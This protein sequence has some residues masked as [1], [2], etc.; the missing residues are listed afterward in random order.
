MPSSRITSL[1]EGFQFTPPSSART[2]VDDARYYVRAYL[3]RTPTFSFW[4]SVSWDIPTSVCFHSRAYVQH[5]MIPGT[6]YVPDA[7]D[8]RYAQYRYLF[9]RAWVVVRMRAW[10]VVCM[11]PTFRPT[12]RCIA[13]GWW[14]A[15]SLRSAQGTAVS[16]RVPYEVPSSSRRTTKYSVR[17]K[18]D[19]ASELLYILISDFVYSW[20]V[21]GFTY[22]CNNTILIHIRMDC[23][24]MMSYVY[25]ITR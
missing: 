21:L 1:L 15:W 24:C 23:C 12:N 4:F 5:F 3:V 10:V 19:T 14:Y 25:Q 18:H 13:S 2:K 8:T 20:Y 9:I 22:F 16:S 7:Y 11:T 17:I 6:C